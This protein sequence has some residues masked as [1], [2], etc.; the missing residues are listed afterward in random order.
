MAA[1]E[2]NKNVTAFML[3]LLLSET[4]ARSAANEG[5]WTNQ[6]QNT[7]TRSSP[8]SQVDDW[9]SALFKGVIGKGHRADSMRTIRGNKKKPKSN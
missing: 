6:T 3:Q 4:A 8:S 9:V 7:N 5:V 2:I 1:E